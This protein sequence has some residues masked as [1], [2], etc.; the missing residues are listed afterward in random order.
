[1]KQP[2]PFRF[3]QCKAPAGPAV[4][5]HLHRPLEASVP[6]GRGRSCVVILT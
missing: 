6:R 4:R 2:C 5:R 1:L 3:C